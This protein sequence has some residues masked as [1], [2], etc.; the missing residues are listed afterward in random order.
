VVGKYAVWKSR[1]S[2]RP[3]LKARVNVSR[4]GGHAGKN[5]A[6]CLAHLG[7]RTFWLRASPLRKFPEEV[8]ADK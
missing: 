8:F 6:F 5:D 7:G 4:G 2:L 1:V 3:Y